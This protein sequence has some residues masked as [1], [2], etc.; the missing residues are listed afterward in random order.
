MMLS[1]TPYKEYFVSDLQSNDQGKMY[2]FNVLCETFSSK[3][4]VK[5]GLNKLVIDK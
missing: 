3:S 4:K 5:F 2:L 1:P